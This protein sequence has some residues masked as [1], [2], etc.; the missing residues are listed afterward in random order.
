MILNLKNSVEYFKRSTKKT[1]MNLT[2]EP[3]ELAVHLRDSKVE[4]DAFRDRLKCMFVCDF[5]HRMHIVSAQSR[6][7]VP[8]FG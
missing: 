8:Q 7:R 1:K 4:L 6:Y 2:Q 3:S 5:I